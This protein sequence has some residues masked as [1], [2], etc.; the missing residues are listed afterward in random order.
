[1]LVALVGRDYL[2]LSV[3]L[4]G[5]ALGGEEFAISTPVLKLVFTAICLGVGFPGG[6]VTPLFVIGSTLGAAL[7][8]VLGVPVPVLAAVGFVAVF[9]GA[10]NTPIASM[11]LGAELFGSAL[12]PALL[13]GCVVAY[14]V[15]GA[16]GIYAGQ[17]HRPV[18]GHHAA[19]RPLFG[20]AA[21]AARRDEAEDG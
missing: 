21:G 6:E 16:H 8:G 9:A 19:R 18:K 12:L 13:V 10:S 3:P 15:S 14:A 7:A 2:G 17:Q 1:V 11:V 5:R 4:A 20:D